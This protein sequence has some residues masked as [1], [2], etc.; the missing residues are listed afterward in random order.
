MRRYAAV[1]SAIV[2]LAGCSGGGGGDESTRDQIF[3][4]GEHLTEA[5]PVGN[6][7]RRIDP[8]TLLPTRALALGDYVN[9]RV[10]SPDGRTMA[11]GAANDGRIVFVDLPTMARRSVRVTKA[12]YRSVW[13]LSWPTRRMLVA[14]SC[15][16]A[17]KFGC[18]E[19]R[20]WRL[21][22]TNP[23]E[24]RARTMPAVPQ[25]AYDAS[26]G[27]TFL[28]ARERQ[29]TVVEPDGRLRAVPLRHAATAL[30]V[31]T[32]R[33]EVI[34]VGPRVPVAAIDVRTLS[35][36]HHRVR[37]LDPTDREIRRVE[38]REWT[39]TMNPH[40]T[41][42][43][44]IEPFGEGRFFIQIHESRLTRGGR[45]VHELWRQAWVD[46]RRWQARPAPNAAW[47]EPDAG[48]VIVHERRKR[49]RSLESSRLV[50]YE[51]DGDV[52]YR[53]DGRWEGLRE[54]EVAAGLIYGGVSDGAGSKSLVF[55][56]A[57]GRLLAKIPPRTLA[58]DNE[59]P[60]FRWT[61]PRG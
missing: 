4:L 61:P 23:R 22:P 15:H 31:D 13:V 33:G 59:R 36:S 8:A 34:A 44:G 25:A 35:V 29:L 37:G 5:G 55:D 20:L 39:G 46:S 40:E 14:A 43:R 11:F 27:R 6:S 21:D 45:A 58:W 57:T 7:L 48:L 9:S 10:L 2:I 16:H 54:W 52:R 3:E 18:F 26:T 28:L 19:T 12:R 41:S 51:S 56:V 49:N 17:G 42:Y 38:P 1:L 32:E 53:L 24:R 50:A 30:A 60:V 47:L